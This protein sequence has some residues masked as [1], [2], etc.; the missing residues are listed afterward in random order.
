MIAAR[1]MPV[2]A[3]PR[4]L[5]I[6]LR[7]SGGRGRGPAR[8]DGRVRWASANPLESPTSPQPS[9]PPGTER[10]LRLAGGGSQR[11]SYAP[12]PREDRAA[13]DDRV[14]GA[15][16]HRAAVERRVLRFRAKPVGVDL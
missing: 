3:M 13:V 14:L 11:S 10:E 12:L 15:A 5:R 7:P 2:I 4:A 8:S 9:P 1:P 6:P 16:L